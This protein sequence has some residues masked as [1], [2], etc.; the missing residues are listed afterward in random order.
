MP[1]Q[2]TNIAV[3]LVGGIDSKT[4][5]KV[6]AAPKLTVLQNG[7]FTKG[8]SVKKR[9]GYTALSQDTIATTPATIADARALHTLGDS[10]VLFD[11]SKV[12]GY[13]PDQ[14]RWLDKGD[15]ESVVVTQESVA[16]V[17]HQQPIADRATAG[18]VTV[19]AWEDSRGGVRCS[20]RNATTGP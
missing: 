1:V 11:D 18:G 14:D 7:V 15:L 16:K 8:G 19:Y 3:P 6:L 9:N 2:W 5:E 10:L 12:Y 17:R 4:D 20:I 13:A